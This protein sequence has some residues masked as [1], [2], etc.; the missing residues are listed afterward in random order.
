MRLPIRLRM[1]PWYAAL[2]PLIIVAVGELPGP[3]AARRPRRRRRRGL[4]PGRRADRPWL[5]RRGHPG[6]APTLGHRAPRASARRRSCSTADGR[7]LTSFGDPVSRRRCSRAADLRAWSPA[8]TRSRDA[9]RSGGRSAS[10]SSRADRAT[11]PARGRRRGAVDRRQSTA[12]CTG[13]IVL[14][15]LAVP[16]AVAATAAAGWWLARRSI[17]PVDARH[18]RRRPRSVPPRSASGSSVRIRGTRSRELAYAF[19][20]MLDRIEAG[21]P[22]SAPADRRRIARAAHAARRDA[23]RDRRQPACRRPVAGRGRRARQRTRGGRPAEPHRRGPADPRGRR[24]GDVDHRRRARGSGRGGG[25]D[26]GCAQRVGRRAR[27][28][29]RARGGR[30]GA[31]PGRSGAAAPRDPQP[32][33]ERDPLHAGRPHRACQLPRGRPRC[34]RRR[35]RRRAGNPGRAARADLRALLPRGLVADARH[36][37]QRP[38]PRDHPPHRRSARW[39]GRSASRGRGNH[40]RAQCAAPAGSARHAGA[41]GAAA[42]GPGS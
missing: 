30:A 21:G 3:A 11:R 38:R 42:R 17:L 16:V 31:D 32:R 2:L 9:R 40:L 39:P 23:R 41:L 36:G 4:R 19:N 25:R 33:R 20:T 10:A 12:R 29:H 22:R 15:L 1:T 35:P 24:R 5:P 6:V 14:L 8:V 34:R 37:R 13:V 28:A 27:G 7:V 26:R 18:R